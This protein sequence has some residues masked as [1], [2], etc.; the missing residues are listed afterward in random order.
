LWHFQ[1][2]LHLFG[3]F[4]ARAELKEPKEWQRFVRMLARKG[5]ARVTVK[6]L[7]EHERHVV[8]R[9]TGEFVA[10]KPYGG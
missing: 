5:R 6:S 10:L 9:F 1:K 3:A 8:G 4:T 2:F 7:L